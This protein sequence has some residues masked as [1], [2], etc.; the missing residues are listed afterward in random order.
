MGL[1]NQRG[2]SGARLHHAV[3]DG[4]DAAFLAG[5][6]GAGGGEVRDNVGED[7]RV[8]APCPHTLCQRIRGLP[9]P[10]PCTV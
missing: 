1:R 4:I 5:P 6:S 8:G 2:A 7:L 10:M 9:P 3:Y